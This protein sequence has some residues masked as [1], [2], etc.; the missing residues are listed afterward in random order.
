MSN[1]LAEEIKFLE[2]FSFSILGTSGINEVK[3]DSTL[4]QIEHLPILHVRTED[5]FLGNLHTSFFQLLKETRREL[6]DD[7]A[8]IFNFGFRSNDLFTLVVKLSV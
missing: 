8:F 3:D 2:E 7:L 4:L 5:F 1:L 6:S